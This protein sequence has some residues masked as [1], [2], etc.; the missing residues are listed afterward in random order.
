MKGRKLWFVGI[1]GAGLSAYAQLARAWGATSVAGTRA[2]AVSR[3]ARRRRGRDLARTGCPGRLGG[4][5]LVG[6]LV[7]ARACAAPSSCASW[8]RRARRSSSPGRTARN[9]GGDDCVRASRDGARPVLA[10]RCA[11]ATTRFERRLRCRVPRRRGRRVG[12]HR[13]LTAGRDRG[14]HEH[15]ARSPHRVRFG[16][17]AARGIRPLARDCRNRGARRP[18][19]RRRACTPRRAEPVERRLGAGRPRAAGVSRDETAPALARFTGTG[20]R[21]EVHELGTDRRRRLRPSSDRDRRDDRRRARAFPGR[22]CRVLFQPHLTRAP[23]IWRGS[24][25][26]RSPEPTT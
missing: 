17:R 10:D 22:D 9:D 20:R 24:S 23:G 8:S 12:P 15:R 21:F 18:A 19:V 6:L 25:Q 11:G 1:G 2:D 26:R 13:L 4:G 3:R 16:R 5:R 7:G 14:R